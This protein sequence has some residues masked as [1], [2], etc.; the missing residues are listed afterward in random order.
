M[1]REALTTLKRPDMQVELDR[2]SLF[3]LASDTRLEILRALQPMRRTVTQLADSLG[4]DKAAVHRHLKTLEEGGFVKRYED[5]GFVYYGLSWK[6]RDLISPGENTR[7]VILLSASL[8][9]LLCAAAFSIAALQGDVGSSV[10]RSP[11]PATD[12]EYSSEE[13]AAMG[14]SIVMVGA[15]T[16]ALIVLG[17]YAM[18]QFGRRVRKPKQ[19]TSPEPGPSDIA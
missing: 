18:L 6:A 16:V 17:A 7:V 15:G 2:K 8:L 13:A 1:F 10:P 19:R 3:A 4:I 12:G 11:E 5:H 9:L 14:V